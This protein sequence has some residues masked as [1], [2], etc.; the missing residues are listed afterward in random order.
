MDSFAYFSHFS[1]ILIIYHIV[2]QLIY[3]NSLEIK[4]KISLFHISSKQLMF[5]FNLKPSKTDNQYSVPYQLILSI[6]I[7][8]FLTFHKDD[9]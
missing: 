4:E 1:E 8:D 6:S 9:F 2:H 3:F 5:E 7:N